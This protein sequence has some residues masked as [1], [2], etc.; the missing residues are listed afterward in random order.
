[1]RIVSAITNSFPAVV[2]TTIDHQYITGTIVRLVITKGHGMPQANQ[3]FGSI[4]VLTPT[5]FA[6]D[7]DTTYYDAFVVPDLVKYTCSQ[8]VAIG[9]DNDILTAAEQNVLPYAAS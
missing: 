1:M 6:I 9:E 2:T 8:C 5:T 7:I 4:L 3:Q